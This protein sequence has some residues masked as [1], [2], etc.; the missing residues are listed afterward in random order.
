MPAALTAAVVLG[1][2]ALLLYD[3]TAVRLDRPGM[4]WRRA[5][6]DRLAGHTLDDP[7]TVTAAVVLVLLG[8]LLLVLALTPGLR[9]VLTMRSPDASVRAGLTR[10]AAGLIVRDRA[11][12]VSGV[13]AVKVTVGRARIRVGVSSHFRELDDVR[14]ELD[15][16]LAVAVD[17]LGLAHAPRLHVRVTRPARKG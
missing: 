9:H 3:V 5:L 7:G 6:A 8:V 2:A 12:E 4:Q 10:K 16:V 11:M 15:T 13:Q 14:T 17:E 1:A